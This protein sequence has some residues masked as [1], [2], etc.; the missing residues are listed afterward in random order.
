[1]SP[2]TND[3]KQAVYWEADHN[4]RP[5]NHP[6]VTFFAKQRLDFLGTWLDFSAIRT[7][8]DVGC[9]DGF[10]NY[11]VAQQLPAVFGGDRSWTMLSR[12]PAQNRL[13]ALDGYDLPFA[14]STFDLVYVWE[15]LH[16]IANPVVTV[17][18]MARVSGE[19]VLLVEP[20][21]YNPGQF[22]FALYDPEH[23][24]VLRYSLNY[25]QQIAQDAGLTIVQAAVGGWIFPN[26]TPL[27]LF[28]LLRHLPY[29]L[30]FIG[31]SNWVLAK[32]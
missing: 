15:V 6:V 14:D 29:H 19:Y 13:V 3:H 28:A 32:K 27:W 17:Q 2:T 12:N 8:L 26:K 21:R 25:L 31:I 1:M 18:E 16:H 11:Y 24:W 5:Y 7:T 30:P 22:G 4:F 23:R 9:G 10:S 20:N